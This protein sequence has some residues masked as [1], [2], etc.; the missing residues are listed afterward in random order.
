MTAYGE[1]DL[2]NDDRERIERATRKRCADLNVLSRHGTTPLSRS[3]IKERQIDSAADLAVKLYEAAVS[4]GVQPVDMDN[5]TDFVSAAIQGIKTRDRGAAAVEFVRPGAGSGR[6]MVGVRDTKDNPI[7]R[8]EY[9][10]HLVKEFARPNQDDLSIRAS[11]VQVA[12][13]L[14]DEL[15][16]IYRGELLGRLA[17]EVA[18][19]F[20]DR[21]GI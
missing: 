14:L 13:E 8:D 21:L 11:D 9:A 12:A 19:K 5:V 7:D 3:L 15:A 20:Y 2:T 1:R 6:H 4:A 10:D 16:A 18:V 17:R